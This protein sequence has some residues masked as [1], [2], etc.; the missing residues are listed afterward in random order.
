MFACQA[1]SV[2]LKN[3]WLTDIKRLVQN[4]RDTMKG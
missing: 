1:A 3:A 2:E 4:D